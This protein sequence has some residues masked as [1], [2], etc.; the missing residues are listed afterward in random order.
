MQ[1]LDRGFYLRGAEE[2]AR[3]LLGTYIVLET[4]RKTPLAARIVE[5]EAYTRDDPASHSFRGA[6][7]RNEVMFREGGSA[8]VYL[9]YGIYECFN[10][11]TGPEGDG[12]AV[13]VR[14]A[15]PVDGILTI[16]NTRFPGIPF[17]PV[18]AVRLLSGPGLLTRGLGI[19]RARHNGISL[20]SGELTIRTDGPFRSFELYA[21]PRIGITK[22]VGLIRRF[23]ISGSR[24]VSRRT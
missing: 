2:V 13:L 12:E 24:A 14:A 23:S 11:V 18:R 9:I 1:A 15:E 3:D 21:G 19:T 17:D 7:A 20:L 6:T 8:Y 5:T 10:A 22:A 16:W 4:E